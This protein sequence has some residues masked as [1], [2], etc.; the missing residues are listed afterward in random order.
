MTRVTIRSQ[1][2]CQTDFRG[3]RFTI[4]VRAFIQLTHLRQLAHPLGAV[5]VHG[6]NG[7]VLLSGMVGLARHATGNRLQPATRDVLRGE[8]APGP[9][10]L[11]SSTACSESARPRYSC[12]CI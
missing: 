1:P 5:P 10:I 4:R 6:R 9:L 3:H 7:Q 2:Y 12:A 11:R 8:L